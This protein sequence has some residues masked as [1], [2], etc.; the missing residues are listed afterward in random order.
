MCHFFIVD[1]CKSL[2]EEHKKLIDEKELSP[3]FTSVVQF[4]RGQRMDCNELDQL[5]LSLNEFIIVKSFLSASTV[6]EVAL[7]FTGSH[8]GGYKSECIFVLFT[9]TID[10]KAKHTPFAYISRHSTYKDE[11]EVLFMMCSIFLIE[12][13]IY[14]DTKGVW[15][16]N[17]SLVDENDQRLLHKLD[18]LDCRHLLELSFATQII[19]TGHLIRRCYSPRLSSLYYNILLR[20]YSTDDPICKCACYSGLG[21]NAFL[22][23]NHKLVFADQEK[24]LADQNKALEQ[25]PSISDKR[26]KGLKATILNHIGEIYEA[27]GSFEPALQSYTKAALDIGSF[28]LDQYDMIREFPIIPTKEIAKWH[29]IQCNFDVA[30][31]IYDKIM[32]IKKLN[33]IKSSMSLYHEIALASSNVLYGN[34][35][36]AHIIYW[37]KFVDFSSAHY[38]S[39]YYNEIARE[40]YSIGN[41]ILEYKKI[42]SFNR[43]DLALE[44]YRKSIDILSYY[45]PKEHKIIAKCYG[46]M[47]KIYVTISNKES[48]SAAIEH[49]EKALASIPSDTSNALLIDLL[50]SFSKQVADAYV[51]TDQFN[52]AIDSLLKAIEYDRRYLHVTM[53]ANKPYYGNVTASTNKKISMC[54]N[55]IADI[56]E[57]LASKYRNKS[58]TDLEYTDPI[59][60]LFTLKLIAEPDAL[61]PQPFDK[62]IIDILLSAQAVVKATKIFKCL[63]DHELTLCERKEHGYACDK[64]YTHFTF[65]VPSWRCTEHNY[66]K[67]CRCLA[68]EI[69]Y[70]NCKLLEELQGI[71]NSNQI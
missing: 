13:I 65:E 60:D 52:L 19:E 37:K 28:R 3:S 2:E 50:S 55:K 30:I 31:A 21:W 58:L 41:S 42:F 56:Y 18:Q 48:H 15:V 59:H 8:L 39:K 68:K 4:Y 45:A 33:Y 29:R 22:Q 57:I 9:I 44:C 36:S 53:D 32:E 66:D 69:Y 6:P 17:L 24:L 64:C 20:D 62:R 16:I 61:E 12:N 35:D 14:D 63:H 5:M 23:E 27:Y 71:D 51:V 34:D 7:M 49:Y 40:Y 47:A 11:D 46:S 70:F 25:C 26:S 67:C 1:I 10:M 43:I 54:Y 38:L